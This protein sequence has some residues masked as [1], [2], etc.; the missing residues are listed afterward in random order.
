MQT[1][2]AINLIKFNDLPKRQTEDAARLSLYCDNIC[3]EDEL[4]TKFCRINL[5]KK[6]SPHS[7]FL[8][9]NISFNR[10]KDDLKHFLKFSI[11]IESFNRNFRTNV[12][13]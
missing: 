6:A 9:L 4:T 3:G 12:R 8:C 11:I 5:S 13:F 10:F 7:F 2:I 1:S